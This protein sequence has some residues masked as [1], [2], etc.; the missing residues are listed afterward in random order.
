MKSLKNILL[1]VLTITI[2]NSLL[3]YKWIGPVS[4]SNDDMPQTRATGNCEAPRNRTDLNVN[5]VRARINTGGDMWWDL[6]SKPLYEVPK[7]SGCHALFAGSIWVGGKDANNQ[8]KFA[9]QRFRASGT[10]FWTGPLIKTGTER[11]NVSMEVCRE[12][13]RHFAINKNMVAKFREW[14]R[15]SHNPDCE[16]DPSYSIPDTILNW[17]GNGP[18]GGYDNVL[19]PYYDYNGDG[20]YNAEDGDFPYYE[21]PLDGITDDKDCIRPRNR[22]S[23]LYGDYT[24]WWVYNDRGNI[25][26]ETKGA[27]IGM[28]FRSQAFAFATNDELNTMT[29]Y[30][31]NITN[32]STYTLF[33]TYFGVWTDADLGN[34][35]D[36]YIGCDIDR[37]LGYLY[38]STN[39]DESTGGHIGYGILPPAI[40]IDF[41]EGPYQD[42][43]GIDKPSAWDTIDG[44]R[45][46]NCAKL[47]GDTTD[48]G[49]YNGNINGLNFG[50]KEIDNERWGMRRFIYF[51]NNVGNSATYDPETAIQYYGYLTGKWL[52]GTRIFFGGTGHNSS[53][54]TNVEA[55]FVFPGTSDKC[56]WGTK[57]ND[58]GRWDELAD[59][60]GNPNPAGDRRFVQSAGPFTL[61]PGA[62]NDITL[63][64]VW[65]RAGSG[66]NLSS[67]EAMKKADDKAQI[68]FETC[69]R[70]LDGPDAPNLTYIET[71]QKIIFQI[72]NESEFNNYLESYIEKDNS[73]IK[74]TFGELSSEVDE[75]YRFQGYQVFQ[76]VDQSASISDRYDLSKA[77]L[78]YQC[79]IRD[80]V[81]NI[82]NYTWN[83]ELQSNVASLEVE[84]SNSGIAHTFVADKD[85]FN[86]GKNLINNREYYFTVIAYGYN[87]SPLYNQTNPDAINFQKTPYLAGRQN[88]K[89]YTVVPRKNFYN[90]EKILNSEYGSSVDITMYEGYGNANQI[91]DL[92]DETIDSIMIGSP[93]HKHYARKY[94]AG[95]GPIAVNII[96]PL[97]VT[98][99][100]FYV[101]FISPKI[102]D[103]GYLGLPAG[104]V[105]RR[106]YSINTYDPI[107]YIIYNTKGDTIKNVVTI[108]SIDSEIRTKNSQNIKYLNNNE[109]LFNKWGFSITID[110]DQFSLFGEL[111]DTEGGSLAN[112]V[113][114]G[115][116]SHSTIFE[117]SLKQWLYFIP[118]LPELNFNW[119]RYGN[120]YSSDTSLYKNNSMTYSIGNTNYFMDPKSS[121]A[122]I[123]VLGGYWAPFS[124]TTAVKAGIFD[125]E[126]VRPSNR[127]DNRV[128]YEPYSASPLSSVDIVFTADTSKWSKSTVIEMSSDVS[129]S[130]GGQS[131]FNL[132]KKPSV[133]KLGN[134]LNDGTEA[135]GW[136]PGYAIDVRTGER[137]NIVFGENSSY[138]R[139]NGNDLIWNPS[140]RLFLG[141]KLFLGGQHV[142]Y[143]LKTLYDESLAFH[144]A[145]AAANT[146]TK[147]ETTFNDNIMWCAIPLLNS[148]YLL[149]VI[150][151][152]TEYKNPMKFIKSDLKIKLRVATPYQKGI[153]NKAIQD[154]ELVQNNNLPFFSFSTSK[155]AAKPITSQNIIDNLPF[156]NIVP[157]PYYAYSTFEK[158]QLDTYVRIT[159]LPARCDI[160]IYN[161]N[162]N[163]ITSF[164]KANNMSYWQWN[165]QNS[166]NVPI[167][168][169]MYLIHIRAYGSNDD[170]N[171]IVGE[172]ILKFFAA[173]RPVDLNNF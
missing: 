170:K 38:N 172:K 10:D 160:K 39:N 18:A 108:D 127:K 34:P 121:F 166:Y 117:D 23:K 46:L 157:N 44:R 109:I 96:N 83:D 60:N 168:S 9:G 8:L 61:E 134:P 101:K 20:R 24:L 50:D 162:G 57:G 136:F 147:L 99:D 78:A 3:A 132:R 94:K 92:T 151:D 40:G 33:Q 146:T 48:I 29:F 17:P 93:W 58:L 140:D 21:F 56:N 35:N 115:L 145:I 142:I 54:T 169:G 63:G 86:D 51:N 5:M 7:G 111:R 6:Q 2:S 28:E 87:D 110:F 74:E 49:L 32:R 30:N 80:D 42:K 119:V 148:N 120:Q 118:N 167:S 14:Y 113:N 59:L 161:S 53:N 19:A 1:I 25:H 171:A 137:L 173:M 12:Y 138:K 67:V 126:L 158:G 141:S 65:A 163:L 95:A 112:Y 165:L 104:T 131:K 122:N 55:D 164:S 72:S 103:Y 123:N 71:D 150:K 43:A 97:N 41:F 13:D 37:G 84:A 91:I 69:F 128:I 75:F 90:E 102:N 22:V 130:E 15:C 77:R 81:T 105:G 70:P 155:I 66:N 106:Q 26:T 36:D 4:Q 16:P 73:I 159:N 47:P 68:L 11:G 62:V 85:L 98:E 114:N 125:E 154:N 149:S 139:D 107:T 133:D 79:D 31:Y 152:S 135:Y 129:V 64:A 52:D 89:N 100:T 82:I 156:V 76:L 27:A 88:I 143:V 144:N 45:V 153:G 116:L 124:L